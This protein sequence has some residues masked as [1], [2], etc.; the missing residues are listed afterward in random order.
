MG[1]PILFNTEMVKAILEGRKTTT[2]RVLKQPFEVHQN[3]FITKPSGNER[4]V[5]YE[6]PYKVGDILY[7]RETWLKADD[8]YHYR[9][10]ATYTSEEQRKEYG[11]KWKPSIHM[12][13]V[14]ARI[15][16]KVSNVKVKKLQ[17]MQYE[18]FQVEGAVAIRFSTEEELKKS[19]VEIWDGTLTK[20]KLEMYSWD[21][22]P[23]V[24]VIEFERVEK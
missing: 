18:D 1:K 20:E 3:G 23:Y 21:V 15:F 10:D 8:G 22:N 17:E 9:A 2:R 19:F 7:V 24:F 12:P 11:Y 13:K 6:A 4:L 16:L 14:A 5:P